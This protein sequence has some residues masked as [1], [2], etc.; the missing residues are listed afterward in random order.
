MSSL[1]NTVG[2]TSRTVRASSVMSRVLKKRISTQELDA[3]KGGKLATET[4]NH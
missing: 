2:R 3:A 4:M 1:I